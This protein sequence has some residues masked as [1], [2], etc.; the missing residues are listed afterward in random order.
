MLFRPLIAASA[1]ALLLLPAQAHDVVHPEGVIHVHD[2]YARITGK[3]SGAVFFMIHNNTQTDDRLIGVS[4]DLAKKAELHTT[5]QDA[6]GVMK[7]RALEGGIALP[8]GEMHELGR[9]G[10]HVMLMGLTREVKPGETFQLLLD[11]EHAPDQTI[12]VIVD[13]DRAPDA[14]G[15]DHSAHGG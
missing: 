11:F 1:F 7:M 10:D 5:E 13:N 12:E 15:M 4:T 3:A 6:A 14:G 8:W 2:A 9:G